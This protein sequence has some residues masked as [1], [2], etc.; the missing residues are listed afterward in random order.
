MAKLQGLFIVRLSLIEISMPKFPDSWFKNHTI[1]RLRVIECGLREISDADMCC[2]KNLSGIQ[3]D[4]NK[5]Q[6]VPIAVNAA[7]ALVTLLVRRNLIKRLQGM[8]DL[9]KL[10]R[11][12][13]SRNK[14]ETLE[15]EYLTGL[16]K[17]RYLVLSQNSIHNLSPKLFRQAKS[18]VLVKLNNNHIHSVEGVFDHL[19]GLEVL[20][21]NLN[22][23]C[24]ADSIARFTLSSLKELTLEHN[25]ISQITRFQNAQI[26]ATRLQRELP[27]KRNRRSFPATQKVDH[28]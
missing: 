25:C 28:P 3:L 16:P 22:N 27:D 8:L 4:G 18:L 1:A 11:L 19:S 15:E 21:L 20:D 26:Q 9:P 23:I 14:I 2:I 13:L 6:G 17:L 12:D 5:L 24:E 10:V 7:R